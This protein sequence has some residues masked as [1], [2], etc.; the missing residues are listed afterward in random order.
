MHKFARMF[1]TSIPK[2]HDACFECLQRRMFAPLKYNVKGNIGIRLGQLCECICG[3]ML[4][5]MCACLCL[6]GYAEEEVPPLS[7]VSKEREWREE[8]DLKYSRE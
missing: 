4:M 3:H 6:C 8:D 2:F 5:C 7:C 1:S